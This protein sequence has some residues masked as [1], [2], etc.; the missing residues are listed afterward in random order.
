M[1]IRR[2]DNNKLQGNYSRNR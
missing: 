2:N 1:R